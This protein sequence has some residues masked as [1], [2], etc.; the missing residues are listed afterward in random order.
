MRRCFLIHEASVGEQPA[1]VMTEVGEVRVLSLLQLLADVLEDE[2]LDH[3]V[4]SLKQAACFLPVIKVPATSTSSASCRLRN[5]TELSSSH[6]AFTTGPSA[7][8]TSSLELNSKRN[9]KCATKCGSRT[10]LRVEALDAGDAFG[11]SVDVAGRR[12]RHG[13]FLFGLWTSF[14]QLKVLHVLHRRT[15]A[16]KEQV[17]L[18]EAQL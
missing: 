8:S 6:K 5:A 15:E 10:R 17:H 7:V 13:W 3:A 16:Y 2:G 9:F 14:R 11:R 12:L 18:E 1:H 4:A